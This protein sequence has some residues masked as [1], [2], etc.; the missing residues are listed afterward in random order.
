MQHTHTACQ[1]RTAMSAAMSAP[2]VHLSYGA[3]SCLLLPPSTSSGTT[4]NVHIAKMPASRLSQPCMIG[5][6]RKLLV[7]VQ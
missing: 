6:F 2:V 7:A 3:R 4:G 5:L 1:R